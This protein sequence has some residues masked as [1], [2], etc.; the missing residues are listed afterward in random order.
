MINL[1]E[2]KV[3][4]LTDICPFCQLQFD[5]GQIEIKEKF[6]VDYDLPGAALCRAARTCTGYEPAG[7]RLN[8]PRDQLRTVPAEGA[9]R[10]E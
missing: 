2:A 3:D 9:V 5:R 1:T 8:L 7:P 10:W 6:G 4:A